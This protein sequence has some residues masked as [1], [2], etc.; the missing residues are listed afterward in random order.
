MN[1][2]QREGLDRESWHKQV[3]QYAVR[4]YYLLFSPYCYILGHDYDTD[5]T[6]TRF[7]LIM[8]VYIFVDEYDL[9][10]SRSRTEK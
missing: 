9:D 5:K 4:F 8:N 1:N 7:I 3:K 2:R 6:V 10:P